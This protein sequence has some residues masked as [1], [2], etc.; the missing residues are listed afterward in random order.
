[1]QTI[2]EVAGDPT[3]ITN[4]YRLFLIVINNTYKYICMYGI[5]TA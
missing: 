4:T 2:K 5:T 1:M 3:V